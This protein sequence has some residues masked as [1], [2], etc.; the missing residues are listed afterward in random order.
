[1]KEIIFLFILFL[2][3]ENLAIGQSDSLIVNIEMGIRGRWQTGNLNQFALNPN[4]RMIFSNQK[5]KTE[6]RA[7]YQ[8]LKVSGFVPVNDLWASWTYKYRPMRKTFPLIK[9][10]GGF[11]K[12]YKIDHSFLAGGGAG[13]NIIHKSPFQ[14]LQFHAFAGYINFQFE[15]EELYTSPAIGTTIESSFSIAPRMNIIWE[16]QSY[17][18]TKDSSFWGGS[19]NIL[20]IFKLSKILSFTINHNTIF[21][22][23]TIADIKN[24]NSLMLF[25]VQYQ[26]N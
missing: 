19:N 4:A 1:M 21:N 9:A 20:L 22:N 23:N 12:S 3:M 11:A 25:G 17:H 10:I 13:I 18:T 6:F 16:I 14:Y 7:D 26:F 24:T 5:F 2:S 15:R 8:Y